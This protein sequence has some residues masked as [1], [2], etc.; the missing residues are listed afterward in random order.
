V[1]AEVARNL[2]AALGFLALTGGCYALL[3]FAERPRR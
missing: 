3:K 1:T 2:L